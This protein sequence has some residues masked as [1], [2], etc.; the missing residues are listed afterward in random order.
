MKCLLGGPQSER[1]LVWW[2]F[3]LNHV[4]Q[5]RQYDAWVGDDARFAHLSVMECLPFY[6]QVG[7]AAAVMVL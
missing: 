6:A 3:Q 5:I 7:G 4:I 2:G 1:S